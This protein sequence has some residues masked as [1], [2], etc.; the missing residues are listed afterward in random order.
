M[1]ESG[2]Q[3]NRS[4]K[5]AGSS[6]THQESELKIR[7]QIT[8]PSGEELRASQGTSTR[9]SHLSGPRSLSPFLWLP[10]FPCVL[11]QAFPNAKNSGISEILQG[12]VS[13]G[14]LG[15]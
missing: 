5:L 12:E 8:E 10:G 4:E 1:P 3:G 14:S 13:K 2:L 6:L 15:V 7:E 11:H 9:T